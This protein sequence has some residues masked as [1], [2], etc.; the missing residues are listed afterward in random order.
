L[1]YNRKLGNIKNVKDVKSLKILR[2]EKCNNIKDY[3]FVYG[4]KNLDKIFTD[5]KERK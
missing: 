1:V 4:L 2:I 3:K 5:I